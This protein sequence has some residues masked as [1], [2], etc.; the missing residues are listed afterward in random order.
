[1]VERRLLGDIYHYAAPRNVDDAFTHLTGYGEV[2]LYVLG[3][4][5][6]P[7][8]RLV[9]AERYLHGQAEVVTAF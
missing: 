6:Y 7:L 5:Y 9:T 1:M 3:S 4:L 2:A 8:I